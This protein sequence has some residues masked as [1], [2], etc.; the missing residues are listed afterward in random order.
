M[1]TVLLGALTV[2]ATFATAALAAV[3]GFGGDVLLL[4]V[5]VAVLGTRDA[6]AVVTVAQ[7]AAMAAGWARLFYGAGLMSPLVFMSKMPWVLP[8]TFRCLSQCFE[9]FCTFLCCI[10]HT[11]ECP[12]QSSLTISLWSPAMAL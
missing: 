7:P 10:S 9:R 2:V 6:F 11:S 8:S 12:A 4:P 1:E 5:F 3:A